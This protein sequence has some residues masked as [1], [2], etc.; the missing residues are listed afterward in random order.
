MDP[1]LSSSSVNQALKTQDS[2]F[3]M[4]TEGCLVEER[5]ESLPQQDEVEDG[6]DA[7]SRS[8]D[9]SS[10]L[11][12]T[13]NSGDLQPLESLEEDLEDKKSGS[14]NSNSKA[15][16]TADDEKLK[17]LVDRCKKDWKK[18]AKKFQREN[19]KITPH[20]LK[21]RFKYLNNDKF[22]LRIKFEHQ[23]DLKLAK[24]FKMHGSKWDLIAQ[25]FPNRTSVMLKNRYYS[26]IRK[27]IQALL[28]ELGETWTQPQLEAH[29]PAQTKFQDISDNKELRKHSEILESSKTIH[30]PT[31]INDKL[32]EK[33]LKFSPENK[34]L[35]NIPSLTPKNPL[36]LL[37]EQL[38]ALQG[39]NQSPY[40]SLKS[41]VQVPSVNFSNLYLPQYQRDL[42]AMLRMQRLKNQLQAQAYLKMTPGF[43]VPE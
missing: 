3:Q 34:L 5:D 33:P 28:E 8:D 38:A 42:I 1:N 23:E 16:T 2:N 12:R 31:I 11:Q 32:A 4:R 41:T 24:L 37:N 35:E 30:I 22:L 26:Y 19:K 36:L 13:P 14:K 7:L 21:N 10:F 9:N 27:N 43:F 25:Q 18:I 39:L 29:A 6:D 40:L 15:W 17:V 20:F